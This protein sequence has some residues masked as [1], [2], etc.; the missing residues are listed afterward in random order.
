MD[1]VHFS[2]RGNGALPCWHCTT[3]ARVA[4]SGTAAYCA[5]LNA[6]KVRSNPANGCSAFNVNPVRMMSQG[7]H[8]GVANFNAL[9]RCA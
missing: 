3:F 8:V 4:Y 1:A 5:Q 9:S 2:P 7:R 6:R